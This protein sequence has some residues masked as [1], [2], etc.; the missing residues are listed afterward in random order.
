MKGVYRLIVSTNQLAAAS[1]LTANQI[2]AEKA[3]SSIT[4]VD[5]CLSLAV[6]CDQVGRSRR[7]RLLFCRLRLRPV[8]S[9]FLPRSLCGVYIPLSTSKY[10]NVPLRSIFFRNL[11]IDHVFPVNKPVS[12]GPLWLFVCC[13]VITGSFRVNESLGRVR[14]L[15]LCPWS[16]DLT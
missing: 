6:L 8:V 14:G 13:R 9:P 4:W 12:S 1:Q 3:G 2:A 7:S 10:D 11:Q 15:A 5:I 16:D